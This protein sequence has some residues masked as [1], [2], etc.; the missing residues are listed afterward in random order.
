MAGYGHISLER[1]GAP[2]VHGLST[3]A[4]LVSK[5]ESDESIISSLGFFDNKAA[6]MMIPN[7]ANDLDARVRAPHGTTG[8]PYAISGTARNVQV[9][10]SQRL[11]GFE[12]PIKS[13]LG[14]GVHQEQKIFIRRQYV[15]G[16]GAGIVPER[17]PART[18]AI[19][20][21]TRE[22]MLTR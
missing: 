17:A 19:Q 1:Q 7:V 3:K 11:A 4:G 8:I 21:D 10:V 13:I 9:R 5:N 15:A 22:V 16:G 12:D 20:E 18:V 6:N 2:S 14:V